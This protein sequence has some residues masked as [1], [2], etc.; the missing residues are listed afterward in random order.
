[1]NYAQ[2]IFISY[3]RIDDE[4]LIE[5]QHGWVTE[6]NI[7]LEKLLAQLM[8]MKPSIWRD[9]KGLQGNHDLSREIIE[10]LP[11]TA[12]LVSILAPRYILSEWCTAELYNFVKAAEASTGLLVNNKSRVFKVI[13]TPVPLVDHPLPVRDQLGYEFFEK[14]PET[15]RVREYNKV[16]GDRIQQAYWA[17]MYD[18]AQDITD[19]LLHL[20]KNGTTVSTVA[21]NGSS[22]TDQKPDQN[23]LSSPGTAPPA[24]IIPQD[25]KKTVYL[26]EV[27]YDLSESRDMIRRELREN[28][29]RVLP[30]KSLPPVYQLYK[31]EITDMLTQAD[32]AIHLVGSYY[33]M[34][35]DGSEKS[36]IEIQN[37]VSAEVN[38]TSGL[39]RIV[40]LPE[41]NQTEDQRNQTFIH[42]L[43]TEDA[44]L[45]EAELIESPLQHLLHSVHDVL[46]QEEPDQEADK[47]KSSEETPL[48]YLI[49]DEKDQEI[50][51][52][53]E[54]YLFDQG[55][56][57]IMPMFEGDE[58]QVR[59]DHQQNLVVCDATLIYYGKSDNF[60]F[61]A[62]TRD[63]QKAP[64]YGRSTPFKAQGILVG[65]PED[66]K[67]QRIR[68]HDAI[69]MQAPDGFNPDALQPFI[70]A[71]KKAGGAHG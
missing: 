31:E 66:R 22:V 65:P 14:D 69:I 18:L 60:W 40:W 54:D 2:D 26:S 67:K 28:G 35:P 5:G 70:N 32:L 17:K 56:E 53:I 55:I 6:F 64:G 27:G 45:A 49:C 57:V 59:E 42:A 8:G 11:K 47:P 63:L 20:K 3:S 4:A 41:D 19:I 44:I 30:D 13:K 25:F 24:G 39:P 10:Q 12:V 16:F 15:G 71:A 36:I 21:S 23:V 58:T 62:M 61:R 33:G 7:A 34:V 51:Y 29:Y 9:V 50:G 43:K 1:M 46:E 48:V 52:Q 38:Q 68:S 37:Q